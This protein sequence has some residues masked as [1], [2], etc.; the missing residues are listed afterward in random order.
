[1]K[2]FIMLMLSTTLIFANTR[3]TS[4]PRTK[5]VSN[6]PGIST[7]MIRHDREDS[8]K[9]EQSATGRGHWN[10]SLYTSCRN[11]NGVW[12]SPGEGGYT[13]CMNDKDM[14]KK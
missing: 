12:L 9:R 14:M 1:M 5:E 13:A 3:D 4:K 2:F 6:G 8:I 7:E 11:Q 10:D